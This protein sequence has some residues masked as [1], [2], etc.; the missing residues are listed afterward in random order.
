MCVLSEA[1]NFLNEIIECDE[2]CGLHDFATNWLQR[3]IAKGQNISHTCRYAI[4][5]RL[6]M[7]E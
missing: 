2:S 5:V 6:Q 1:I 4:F 7:I 3:I